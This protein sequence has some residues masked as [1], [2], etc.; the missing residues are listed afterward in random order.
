MYAFPEVG[1]AFRLITIKVDE[2]LNKMR[3]ILSPLREKI[4]GEIKTSNNKKQKQQ[5]TKK[6]EGRKKMGGGGGGGGGSLRR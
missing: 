1:S 3:Y 6:E 4:G 5:K 2:A